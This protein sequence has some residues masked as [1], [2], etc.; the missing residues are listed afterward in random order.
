MFYNPGDADRAL[1]RLFEGIVRFLPWMAVIDSFQH[2]LYTHPGHSRGER[3]AEWLR[4]LDRL[5]P[6]V[7]WSGWETAGESSWQRQLH[8]FGAPFY[9][10]EYGI[11]QLGAL[12]LWMK[13]RKTPA[14]GAQLPLGVGAGGN[15]AVAGAFRGGGDQLRLFGTDPRAADECDPRR[16][17][18]TAERLP[19]PC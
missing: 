13:S 12:Q 16:V 14:G 11:A 15:A 6:G 18:A 8:L 1:C 7:D 17:G 4:I 19:R 5:T 2:W 10:I 3:M 9:Y